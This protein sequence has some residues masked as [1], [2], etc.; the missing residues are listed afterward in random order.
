MNVYLPNLRLPSA[1]QEVEYIQSSWTHVFIN[2]V[3]LLWIYS[4]SW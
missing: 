4:T 3:Q 2:W 1:Y